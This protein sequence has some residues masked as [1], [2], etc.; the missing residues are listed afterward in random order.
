MVL[1]VGDTVTEHVL[2]TD[3]MVQ[4]FAKCTGD[5]NPIHLDDEYAKTTRFK[6][7][8]AH[9]IL[10]GGLIS[11][12]LATKLGVGGIY[13]AQTLKFLNPVFIGDTISV[14]V[15]VKTYRSERGI[16]SID[17]IAKNQNGDTVVKGEA[18]IMVAEHV[19]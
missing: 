13:L 4:M 11:R 5:Y 10:T 8:I 12:V 6:R 18:T 1:K 14:T 16:A 15:F 3:E 2:I 17:T 7:R 9:G 19:G